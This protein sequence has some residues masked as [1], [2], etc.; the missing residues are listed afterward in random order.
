MPELRLVIL[1]SLNLDTPAVDPNLQRETYNFINDVI[2][3]SRPVEDTTSATVLL[4]HLPL[5]K[6]GGVCSDG[7]Y[8]NF[9]SDEEGAGVKEQNHLSSEAS[10]GILEGI[11]GMSGNLNAPAK[12]MGRKGIILTGHDHEG[13][14][15][16]HHFPSDAEQGLPKWRAK[17]W[18]AVRLQNQ[19]VPGIR[20]VTV[21]SMMGSFGGNAGLL[22]AWFDYRSQ[23]WNFG[24]ST[25]SVGVQHI[26]WSIHILNL[27][28]LSLLL[29]AGMFILRDYK[30]PLCS[31][32]V[33][34]RRSD[35]RLPDD[36]RIG[37]PYTTSAGGGRGQSQNLSGN[38]LKQ[39]PVQAT[40]LG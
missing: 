10:K 14:D 19:T 3:A 12:G 11:F 28:T 35:V 16:Y 38:K 24:Y 7:P 4:T 15:T 13:C 37:Q 33:R 36:R 39:R 23:E 2:M 29:I 20:E 21:R 1:N 18:G 34:T 27:I 5:H 26:W 32:K 8:F 31:P 22:S 17:N 25:C 6:E 30:M 40:K 9:Y